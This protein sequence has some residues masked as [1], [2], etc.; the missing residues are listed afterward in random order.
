MIKT[1]I[2]NSSQP[3]HYRTDRAGF[4]LVEMVV[5]I[6]IVA[7]FSAVGFPML[8]KWVPSTNLKA[9]T[10]ELYSGFQKARLHAAKTNNNVTFSFTVDADCLAPTSYRFTDDDGEV[11]VSNVMDNGVCLSSSTFTNVPVPSGFNSRGL[12]TNVNGGTVTLKHLDAT[13]LYSIVQS[14]AGNIRIQ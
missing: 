9:A 1:I 12:P 10:H 2:N 6:I 7:I 14:G 4:T 5:V 13:K 3:H 11:V 8:M